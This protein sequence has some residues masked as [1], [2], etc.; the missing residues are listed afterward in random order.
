VLV[1]REAAIEN[2]K[3]GGKRLALNQKQPRCPGSKIHQ[4]PGT[5]NIF[6]LALIAKP[7]ADTIERRF[8]SDC[9][10]S[11]PAQSEPL[12]AELA[13]GSDQRL[14]A[15]A[16]VIRKLSCSAAEL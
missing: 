14:S 3:P 12:V 2:Q 8:M 13:K 1:L 7:I 15:F 4:K 5:P 16:F 6:V 9:S 10:G 11:R